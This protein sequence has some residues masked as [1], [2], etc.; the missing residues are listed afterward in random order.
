MKH[1]I[2]SMITALMMLSAVLLITGCSQAQGSKGTTNSSSSNAVPKADLQGVWKV[3][4]KGSYAMHIY[5][6]G[7]TIYA[8]KD[9][10]SSFLRYPGSYIYNSD[11]TITYKQS[12]S[13]YKF[14]PVKNGET[15]D[16]QLN[17]KTMMTL[18]KDSSVSP[19]T[20][21]NALPSG[22]PPTPPTP[23]T[24]ASADELK[25]VWKVTSDGEYET[26]IYFDGLHIY[27]AINASGSFVKYSTSLIYKKSDGTINYGGQILKPIKNGEAID[28]YVNEAPSSMSM[29]KDPSV[30]PDAITSVQ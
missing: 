1:K 3:T 16:L 23:G 21:K 13:E 12:H 26:H 10:G 2:A 18:T 14:T 24:M 7:T 29:T 27:A 17:E 6:D 22:T 4:V 28:L 11:G 19:D 20:I 9:V 5:F 8:A 15:I 25:G 30:L